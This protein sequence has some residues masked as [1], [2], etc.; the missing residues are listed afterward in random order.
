[1]LVSK[2]LTY[3]LVMQLNTGGDDAELVK[4]IVGEIQEVLGGTVAARWYQLGTVLGTPVGEL[5]MIRA[6]EN[7]T[8]IDRQ[9][10]M[11][12]AWL[13]CLTS[14]KTWQWLVDSIAHQA[15]GKHP[16]LAKKIADLHPGI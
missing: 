15:G 1:M 7:L 11:L 16:K 13:M 5:E 2:Q 8:L 6:T 4:V 9:S 12:E 14:N 10:M 3:T